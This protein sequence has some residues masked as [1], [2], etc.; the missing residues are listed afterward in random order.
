MWYR[1]FRLTLSTCLPF[2]LAIPALC[3]T[4]EL[5]DL[6][7]TKIENES[8]RD[9]LIA[10][11]I[12]DSTL[13]SRPG[14]LN[15][16]SSPDFLELSDRTLE[17]TYAGIEPLEL[18]KEIERRIGA[19]GGKDGSIWFDTGLMSLAAERYSDALFCFEESTKDASMTGNPFAFAYMARAHLNLANQNEALLLHREAIK[20]ASTV[21]TTRF[22]IHFMFSMDL[23]RNGGLSL[24]FAEGGPIHAC[25][26]SE[27]PPEKAFA[28]YEHL[29][30]AWSEENSNDIQSDLKDLQNILQMLAPRS[31]SGFE[32]RRFKQAFDLAQRVEAALSGDTLAEMI[33]D[34]ECCDFY[35]KTK[36]WKRARDRLKPWTEKNPL[37]DYSQWN[38]DLRDAVT[39]VHLNY[40]LSECVV[41]NHSLA[42]SGFREFLDTVPEQEFPK[43][44]VEARCWLGYA[45]HLQGRLS[46]AENA[47]AAGL[48]LDSSGSK[49]LADNLPTDSLQPRIVGGTM[50]NQ[51]RRA[52]VRTYRDTLLKLK[53]RAER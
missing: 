19:S 29:L 16:R 11:P 44:V 49:S 17:S 25:L 31:D 3:E 33:L 48:I 28:L 36:Q 47:L 46:E 41:G 18:H 39:W 42:E 1:V 35:F 9:A 34:E 15:W 8:V 52:F 14:L 51:T 10:N 22:Q 27:Y 12:S 43:K 23:Y 5:S 40:L 6:E 30:H 13:Y 37:R 7:S 24:A 20:W 21:P 32:Q 38:S 45:L 2:I 26:S 50:L 53:E 4:R